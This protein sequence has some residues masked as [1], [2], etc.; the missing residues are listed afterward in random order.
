MT[1]IFVR[2]HDFYRNI[3]DR[4]K[5]FC[6]STRTFFGT[7]ALLSENHWPAMMVITSVLTEQQ[8]PSV[9]LC[10][11]KVAGEHCVQTLYAVNQ[12]Q[13]SLSQMIPAGIRISGLL[14][15]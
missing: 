6:S 15:K 5:V 10:G 8:W 7:G 4:T 3:L 11:T 1:D 14:R 9:P 12:I 13:A 2:A